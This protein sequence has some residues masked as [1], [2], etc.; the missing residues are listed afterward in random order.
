VREAE[1]LIAGGERAAAL[2]LV[3]G[4]A[5]GSPEA[6]AGRALARSLVAGLVRGRSVTLRTN[7]GARFRFAAT[8]AVLGRDP[9]AEIPLRDPGVSRRHALLTLVAGEPSLSDA[10]SRAG[11]FVGGAR[12]AAPLALRG[13][14]DVTLGTGC[15]LEIDVPAPGRVALRGVSG[16]DRTLTAMAGSGPLPL[17]DVVPDAAGA[18]IQIDDRGVHLGHVPELSVR[19]AGHYLSPHVDLLHGDILEIG[20]GGLRL[21]VE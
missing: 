2:R 15:R 4:I 8:P 12:L 13:R 14:N 6:A 11:T 17:G 3:E 9:L 5:D 19:V 21:E 10:G 18:W 16:L 20:D 7:D 1:A